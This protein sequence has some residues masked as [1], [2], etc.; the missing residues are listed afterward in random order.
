LVLGFLVER[1][2]A[3]VDGSFHNIHDTPHATCC[4]L[5]RCATLRPDMKRKG[6][7]PPAGLKPGERVSDYGRLTVRLPDDV[8]AE[9]DAIAFVTG[10]PQWRILIE[11]IQAYSGSGPGLG[12]DER[13]RIRAVVRLGPK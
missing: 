12:D 10:R 4:Q 11:A 5:L 8:R 1:R 7:H 2:D 3:S 13:K 6:G 9:L